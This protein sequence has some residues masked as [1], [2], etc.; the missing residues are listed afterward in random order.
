MSEAGKGPDGVVTVP[1]QGEFLVRDG[2]VIE[3]AETEL[4]GSDGEY[5]A[6]TAWVAREDD[7]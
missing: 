4:V 7:E 1:A 5:W 3:I 2:K 6:Y